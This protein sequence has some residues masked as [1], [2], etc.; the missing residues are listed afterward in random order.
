MKQRH[1]SNRKML[2]YAL[3]SKEHNFLPN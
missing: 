1:F 3:M 2:S